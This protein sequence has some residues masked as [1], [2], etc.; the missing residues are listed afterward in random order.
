MKLKKK[1]GK[2]GRIFNPGS[3]HWKALFCF[4]LFHLFY[5]VLAPFSARAAALD[6]EGR[7]E[8]RFRTI[9]SG[10]SS[11][12]ITGTYQDSFGFLWVGTNSGLNRYDG[13]E[14]LVYESN[15]E[16]NSLGDN[17]IGH[18]Y[19]DG[20][21]DFWIGG[22]GIVSRY[23]RET[24]DFQRYPLPV[25]RTA[26]ITIV[27]S[28]AEEPAGRLWV[29]GG[30]NGL[31]YFCPDSD[32]FIAYEN[33][34]TTSQIN[35]IMIEKGEYLWAT[36]V[37]GLHRLELSSG[38]W[39]SWHYDSG[40]PSSL[41]SNRT[42]KV[43]GDHQGEIWISTR[44]RGLNRVVRDDRGRI[45]FRRYWNEPGQK[46]VL[47]N[48]SIYNMYVDRE[49]RL[50]L[51]ND[52][53]GL[54]LYDRE[55]DRFFH[56][57]S[58]PDDPYSLS[59]HS[60][61]HVFQDRNHRLWVGTA[62]AGLNVTDPYDFK[63][64]HHHTRSRFSRSL[65]NNIVRDFIEDDN[66]NLW[67]ATDGGGLNFFDRGSGHFY[68]FRH[69]PD[70]PHSL[71]SDAAIAVRR[72]VA[73]T[74]WVGSYAGGLDLLVDEKIGR[75]L[76]VQD[77]LAI[78]GNL[79]TNVFDVHFDQ[80]YPYIWIA[81][82]GQGLLRYDL[83]NDELW[84]VRPADDQADGL[85]SRFILRIYEDSQ[86]NLWFVTLHGLYFLASDD[87]HDPRFRAYLRS[88]DD[89]Y[90]LPGNSLRDILEDRRGNIWV[91]TI[92]GLARYDSENDR[93]LSYGQSDGLPANEIRSLAEDD[94]GD[95]W[96]G[97]ANGLSHFEYKTAVF[98]NY[99]KEDGLQGNEFSRYAAERLRT[100][101]LVFGGMKGFNI[102][103]PDSIRTNPHIPEVYLSGF[104]IFNEPVSVGTP[105]SPLRQHIM[106]TDTIRISWSQNVFTFEFIALNYTRAEQNQYAY[107]M[108]GF[109]THWNYVGNQ[110]NATY[111]NLDPGTYRFRVKASNNDG[112]WN[113]EGASVVLVI[114]PPFWR[115]WVFYL[116]SSILI[117]AILV[118]AVRSRLNRVKQQNLH[119]E[120]MV[121]RRTA[122]LRES[123]RRL[124]DY[125]AE[126]NKIYS[127]LAHDLRNP[128]NS[129]I[130]FSEYLQ[131]KFSKES[132]PENH[133]VARSIFKAA[134]TS[135]HLLENLL[136]WAGSKDQ[137]RNL[138]NEPVDMRALAKEAI[139]Q[140]ELQSKMKGVKMEL[141]PGEPVVA[142]A[143]RNM[144][145][146]VLRNLIT[147]A[148][149][150]SDAGR[151]VVIEVSAVDNKVVVS[152]R[153]QGI[154]MTQEEVRGILE[155]SSTMR[156]EGTGGEKGS[157][158]GLMLSQEFLLRHN[159]RL[160]VE[161]EPGKGSTFTFALESAPEEISRLETD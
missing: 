153:D 100:G 70:D 18:M 10:L 2:E 47:S 53:G 94:N 67:I 75:F 57:D 36:S 26:F 22:R 5:F 135:F 34:P 91:A 119:L 12:Q 114:V 126:K 30:S 55:K 37:D 108:E 64:E 48:N 121:N 156:K 136:D 84:M 147:N 146:T 11:Q 82:F 52:N 76:G 109:E 111:T 105:E 157:G 93:F 159:S 29:S 4:C 17:I 31:Y 49:G 131:E 129:I 92:A 43:V 73:G 20:N 72:D 97:T 116:A 65:S 41:T 151:E 101:E 115:T 3:Y 123:N 90:S 46:P 148:I 28:I 127:L 60:I 138:E 44:E 83:S 133:D 128:F 66:G 15:Q 85:R 158:F 98:K 95:L 120:E 103:H 68:A 79:I 80:E 33:L 69:D 81:S 141:V 9:T 104:R 155:G 124:N 56:Y 71:K 132:D 154:G 118:W 23:R 161:S 110:R 99:K 59:H 149:K 45:H 144:I 50:W 21:G 140:V 42:Y 160:R 51:A 139:Q 86:S 38:K 130:G 112:V 125:L 122:E 142:R 102:F 8:L 107:K 106:L 63:F 143:D 113:E 137:S 35:G 40:D 61:T 1:T 6:H 150:F 58:D 13:V 54:H 89:P 32:A 134:R 96:I 78:P 88:E 152:V 77:T 117:L 24:D 87:K 14:F 39:D 74:L 145:L 7:P 27:W 62:L 25:T 19:E 16:T